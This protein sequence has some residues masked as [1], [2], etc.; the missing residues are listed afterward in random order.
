MDPM[1]DPDDVLRA[2]RSR[3]KSYMFDIAFDFATTQVRD[4]DIHTHFPRAT[5]SQKR[6][7]M[8]T[9]NS[10]L[11]TVCVRVCVFSATSCGVTTNLIR[12]KTGKF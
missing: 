3:E 5:K 10:S 11:R 8:L 12:R 1:E 2:N 6:C 4:P 9:V 7:S